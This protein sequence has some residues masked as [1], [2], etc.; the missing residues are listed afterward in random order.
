M[1]NEFQKSN[2]RWRWA[3]KIFGVIGLAFILFVIG[4]A[5]TNVGVANALCFAIVVGASC[6]MVVALGEKNKAQG[7]G[8]TLAIIILIIAC[9]LIWKAAFG[10][11]E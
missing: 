5:I 8:T 9:M 6:A 4:V 10:I 11:K 1:N 7:C 3:L 2:K